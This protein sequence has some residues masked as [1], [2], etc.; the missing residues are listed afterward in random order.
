ML[1]EFWEALPI[2]KENATTYSE[3]CD[4]WSMSKRKV[5][6]TLH[7]L[8]LYDSGDDYVLIR[9]SSG[10][11]FYKT[12]DIETI[13]A[14]KK[15]CTNKAKS[16]F[17]PLKKINRVLAGAEDMQLTFN[18][19]L[20]NAR[21]AKD[22]TQAEAVLQVIKYDNTLDVAMLSKYENGVAV[23][24]PYQLLLLARIYGC[25]PLDL[26]DYQTLFPIE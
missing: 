20:R 22:L 18:N 9:S 14:F 17:A 10:K 1:K 5:R 15:E 2:G 7:A 3:L 16:N 25:K 19:N 4:D 11:G 21:L 13:K 6:Q 24:T 12:D 23:P 26:V 8:S